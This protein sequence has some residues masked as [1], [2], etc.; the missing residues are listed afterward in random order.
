MFKTGDLGKG[1]LSF[2]HDRAGRVR[3]G[4]ARGRAPRLDVL[5]VPSSSW[6]LHTMSVCFHQ[7]QAEPCPCRSLMFPGR[8][9]SHC[10][11][12]DISTFRETWSGGT[13]VFPCD[14]AEESW[15]R[16]LLSERG[17]S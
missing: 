2:R 13:L 7:P 3:K 4:E 9:V 6:W 5:A 16:F 12:P 14:I 8:A 15:L 10:L 17:L 1:Q 11:P